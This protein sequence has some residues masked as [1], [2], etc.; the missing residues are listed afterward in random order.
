MTAAVSAQTLLLRDGRRLEYAEYGRSD[1]E[2]GFY[3]RERYL[4][5]QIPNCHAT[6]F[7]EDGHLLFDH[8][9]EIARA[10]AT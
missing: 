3:F 10:F 1:G 4:A 6:F 2:P 8:M 7:P 9:S 5:V